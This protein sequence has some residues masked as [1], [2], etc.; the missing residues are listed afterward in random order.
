M[1]PLSAVVSFRMRCVYAMRRRYVCDAKDRVMGEERWREEVEERGTGAK[2]NSKDQQLGLLRE[3][4]IFCECLH[5][6]VAQD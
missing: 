1:T 3:V 5:Q 4:R 6:L 2:I